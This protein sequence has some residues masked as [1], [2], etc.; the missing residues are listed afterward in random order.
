MLLACP[1]IAGLAIGQSNADS[2]TN[3][4]DAFKYQLD[5]FSNTVESELT[6]M[7]ILSNS[8]SSGNATATGQPADAKSI[9]EKA[10]IRADGYER[11]LSSLEKNFW[12][13]QS[14]YNPGKFSNKEDT[15]IESR[16][17]AIQGEIDRTRTLIG[18]MRVT[19][20]RIGHRL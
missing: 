2:I 19:A 11:Q 16:M 6:D 7:N 5:D 9:A 20:D 3:D 14:R 18:D 4:L 13:V 8:L 15:A 17:S 10:D 1:T 12:T